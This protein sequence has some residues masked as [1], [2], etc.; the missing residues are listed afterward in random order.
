M[1]RLGDLLRDV[2]GAVFAAGSGALEVGG[3][4]DDSRE[5]S[6]GEAF[7]AIV[8]PQSDGRRFITQALQKGAAAIVTD[9]GALAPEPGARAWVRVP[10]ARRA[11]A[12]M[13]LRHFGALPGL[14]LTGVT[15]TNG[16]TTLTYLLESVLAAAGR[17]PGVVGTVN[18]RFE[19]RH[20]PAPLTTPGAVALQRVFGEMRA[21]GATD[22]VMEVSSIA[23][24]QDRVH[25]CSY[26]VAGLTNVTQDHLDYHGT[27][28]RYFA[29][30]IR[31]F[32]ERLTPDG[33]AVLPAD[34][35][36]GLAMRKH[37]RGKLLT[38]STDP[39]VAADVVAQKRQ[40][41]EDGTTVGFAS[42]L[43]PLEITSPLVGAFNLAN[44][45][46]AVGMGVA[47][48]LSA[49]ALQE[50]LARQAGVPGRLE[51][52]ANDAGILCVVDYA[53][54]PDAL[55]R[56]LEVLRPLTRGRL[57]VV[58][59]CGGDRDP[60]K[61]PLMGAA[62]GRL[63]DLVFVTSD[64]PRTED[65]A[66]IVAMVADGVRQSGL[67]EFSPAALG[68]TKRGFAVE[69]DRRAAIGHAVAAAQAGDTVLIAGKGHE[70]YQILGTQKVHF[71]DREE[72]AAAFA[73]RPASVDGGTD[74]R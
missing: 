45:T 31:L 69:P 35:P 1:A 18:Y 14:T 2:E 50:G 70:D 41:S 62:A 66:R 29:A 42:P 43:G 5:V 52:V 25:G 7:V 20:W 16:K 59:G 64:N 68:A 73:R 58:F 15:G 63:A 40:L 72:A 24:E 67:G 21:A 55:E 49:D 51:R 23:L 65:P 39:A 57:L 38:V 47:H 12:W 34:R 46:L 60:G 74:R 53:H 56:A 3:V 19:D 27:M 37:V 44:L 26:R 9:D 71:D 17:R 22:V 48:G 11:L 36:E 32:E 28:E 54:T 61:R 4:A 6:A 33:V 30:K 10:N 13:A 8:G